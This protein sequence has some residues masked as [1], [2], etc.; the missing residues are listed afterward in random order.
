MA[1]G[2]RRTISAAPS[3]SPPTVPKAQPASLAITTPAAT[4]CVASPRNVQALQ[5]AGGH[6]DLFAAGAS[7]VAQAADQRAGIDGPQGIRAN[8]Y[9]VLGMKRFG[10]AS[11]QPLAVKPGPLPFDGPVQLA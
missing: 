11:L 9:V 2:V 6:E 7:Q 3:V 4:S 8:A 1:T 10:V 5:P